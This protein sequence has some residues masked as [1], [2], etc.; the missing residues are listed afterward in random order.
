MAVKLIRHKACDRIREFGILSHNYIVTY[1]LFCDTIRIVSQMNSVTHISF[2]DRNT[3]VNRYITTTSNKKRNV[4]QKTP[5][6]DRI[7]VTNYFQPSKL[8]TVYERRLS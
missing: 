8:D 4:S 5:L 6:C 3:D 2:C 7:R 1:P